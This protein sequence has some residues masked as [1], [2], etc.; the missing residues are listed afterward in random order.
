MCQRQ[1]GRS[2]KY[3]R[4]VHVEGM[5]SSSKDGVNEWTKTIASVGCK[6]RLKEEQLRSKSRRK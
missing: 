2:K 4:E 5:N 3:R 1:G 6:I